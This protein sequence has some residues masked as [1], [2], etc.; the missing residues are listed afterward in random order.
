MRR[1]KTENEKEKEK[2]NENKNENEN[3]NEN[4]EKIYTN[5]VQIRNRNIQIHL[6]FHK[7]FWF[8][9]ILNP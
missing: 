3:E 1:R 7:F 8:I 5:L 6:T 9:C 2:E 4:Y